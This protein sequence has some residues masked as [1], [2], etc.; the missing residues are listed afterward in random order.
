MALI[1]SGSTAYLGICTENENE[2]KI[3]ILMVYECHVQIS[4]PLRVK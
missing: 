1:Y 3:K 2:K 4:L